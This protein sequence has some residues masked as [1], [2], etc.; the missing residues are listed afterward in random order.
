MQQ[1]TQSETCSCAAAGWCER[2][3]T[4]V[5]NMHWQ[6][7]RAG[8]VANLDDLYS[9]PVNPQ[10]PIPA[11]PAKLNVPDL[12]TIG[13]QILSALESRIGSRISCGT[14]RSYILG[15]NRQSV[16]NHDA[17]VD[18]L[19]RIGLPISG[20]VRGAKESQEWISE[21][22]S[23]V[24]PRP[25]QSQ[26]S[27]EYPMKFVTTIQAAMRIAKRKTSRWEATT[28]SIRAAGFGEPLTFCEPDAGVSGDY[29]WQSKLGPIG[30]FKAMCH[31]LVDSSAE[32]LLLCEDDI[33]LSD[34]TADY[35][36]RFNLTNEVLSLY[37]AKHRQVSTNL[38]SEVRQPLIGS[39]ALLLRKSTL[40]TLMQSRQW[41]TWPKHDCVD[42]LVYRACKE[43]GTPL[44]THRP[45]LVQHTGD[46]A[47]I[48]ADRKLTGN[49]I[50]GDWTQSGS[51]K[52]P[53]VTLITPTGDR[54]EAFAL[55]ERWMRQQTY[56]GPTQWIV[57]DDGIEPTQCTM[58]QEY[59]REKPLPYHSL[60][61]NLRTAIPR[62]KGDCVL[63][64][65]D[66]DFYHP[67]YIATMTGRLQRADLVAEFGA[68]YY[69]LRHQS[70]RHNHDKEHHG[71]LCRTGMNRVV[72][73]TLRRCAQGSHPSVDLRL[74]RQWRGSKFSWRDAAG[75]QSLCVGIKGVDGRQ[76]YGWRPS[77][78]ARPDP[79]LLTLRKW[80]G[81]EA[82]EKYAAMIGSRVR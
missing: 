59:I 72:I 52:P 82:A 3:Q 51:W 56:T 78:N 63:I 19:Y 35:L 34:H 47:A 58:G 43:T 66:D 36:R 33:A 12:S 9:Q 68:K 4:R 65:E 14:C 46:T 70:F 25:G 81:D 22:I 32:W 31:E 1:Q 5:P 16:H 21:A 7:C 13:T 64:I 41:K 37:T 77:K 38:W 20:I 42:Q 53:L 67:H 62:I 73:D 18:E 44:M 10:T 45:S 61:R 57:V 69:Y 29:V 48:Y 8:M 50:A 24:V 39:L 28:E 54:P 80:V 71:S 74:W 76:S 17:L 49:R 30:S 40:E 6:K 60:C 55:C 23:G 2:R 75:T 79:G 15:L 26:S 27:H 11:K